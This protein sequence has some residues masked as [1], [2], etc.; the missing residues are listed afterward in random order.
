M[1][2]LSKT[3]VAPYCKV[4]HD[5]GKPESM[6]TSHFIRESKV[7]GSRVV[8]P[9]LLSQECRYC[10][11]S[12][13]TVKY[14]KEIKRVQMK[15]NQQEKREKETTV[16][17][18]TDNKSNNIYYAL[19][20]DDEEE[21]ETNEDTNEDIIEQQEQEQTI[22]PLSYKN[23]IEITKKQALQEELEKIQEEEKRKAE[24][25]RKRETLAMPVPSLGPIP[26]P[27]YIR[28][29]INWADDSTSDE[30]Y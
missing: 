8:C 4:C 3:T 25:K 16:V 11:K 28:S 12:G 1:S 10:F 30:D 6:Y 26:A 18:M 15:K 20:F 22:A 21:N 24:E 17:A 23:I 13:H 27:I 29:A 7:P 5:A 2:N 19:T 9:T 14:C